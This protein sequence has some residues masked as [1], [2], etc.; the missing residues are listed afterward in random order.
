MPVPQSVERSPQELDQT[1]LPPPRRLPRTPRQRDLRWQPVQ[2]DWQAP[3][4][5][6][7][8]VTSGV[9]RDMTEETAALAAGCVTVCRPARASQRAARL[10]QFA[11]EWW[12]GRC[13]LRQKKSQLKR[14]LPCDFCVW[15]LGGF[16]VV[17]LGR[18]RAAAWLRGFVFVS[19]VRLS[20]ASETRRA[21]RPHALSVSVEKPGELPSSYAAA[22]R[23]F[24]GI[25]TAQ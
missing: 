22:L 16:L 1:S 24:V 9:L 23:G 20:F 8:C 21:E 25:E 6:G 11:R 13:P 4:H 2:C 10:Q 7:G 12:V 19:L 5:C 17:V 14:K 18:V 15:F 3:D